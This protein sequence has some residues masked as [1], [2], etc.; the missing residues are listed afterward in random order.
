MGRIIGIGTDIASVERILKAVQKVS[1]LNKCYTD[2]E[3]ELI[4]KRKYSA[5]C[6]FAG[7]EAIAKAL[8]TGFSGILPSDIE[9]L[10]NEKGAP[11]VNLYGKAK[12]TADRL[13][14]DKIH[15]SLSDTKENAIA[16][17]VAEK[18]HE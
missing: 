15:I 10:R 4:E 11:Y 2:K 18:F 12:E 17:V 16:Y 3:R 1:F 6:N 13:G 8:G 14:I 9:I 7:K 5:A